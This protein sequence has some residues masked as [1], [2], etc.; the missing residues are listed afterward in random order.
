MEHNYLDEINS[1]YEYW[2][3]ELS[4]REMKLKPPGH[5]H[6]DTQ[7]LDYILSL[8]DIKEKRL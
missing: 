4:I 5:F 2:Q 7:K 6:K 3:K 1:Q 8:I